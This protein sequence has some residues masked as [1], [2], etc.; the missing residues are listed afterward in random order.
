[1]ISYGDEYDKLFNSNTYGI[2][3]SER[4]S[5]E[6]DKVI[7]IDAIYLNERGHSKCLLDL[8][9]HMVKVDKEK[10]PPMIP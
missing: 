3:D 10:P 2:V 8:Y 9:N 1:M 6:S 7:S 4:I 5:V